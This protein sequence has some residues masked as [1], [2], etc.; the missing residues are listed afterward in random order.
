M[1]HRVCGSKGAP[2]S[3]R[4]A[5]NARGGCSVARKAM[6]KPTTMQANL[7]DY[8][9]LDATGSGWELAFALRS[10]MRFRPQQV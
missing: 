5:K 10:T 4:D 8:P 2:V 9:F 1:L 7:V 6:N 3:V